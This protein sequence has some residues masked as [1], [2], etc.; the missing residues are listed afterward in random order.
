[1]SDALLA[2]EIPPLDT[3]H[4]NSTK[5]CNLGCSFCYDK[6]VRAPTENLPLDLIRN[7]ARDAAELGARRVIL[8]GGEPTLR[9]DWRD[10]ARAFDEMG[11]EVSLATNGTLITEEVAEFLGGLKSVSLSISV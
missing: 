6:A 8:S 4:F 2:A 11:M 9:K 7:L 10:V 5:S 1:M 3:L